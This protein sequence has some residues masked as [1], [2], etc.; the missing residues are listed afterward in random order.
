MAAKSKQRPSVA[1]PAA[2][3]SPMDKNKWRA[4]ELTALLVAVLVFAILV[5]VHFEQQLSKINWKLAGFI[6]GVS[7]LIF[8]VYHWQAQG[9]NSYD[10]IDMVMSKGKA[11]LDKHLTVFSFALAVWL[12]VQQALEKQPVTELMLGVLGF[13]VFKRGA[14]GFSDA[15]QNRPAAREPSQNVNVLQGASVSNS[16]EAADPDQIKK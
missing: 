4:L 3:A 9:N 2:P 12:I 16:A 6:V 13:F 14:Q 8:A 7:A 15:L 1:K 10:V 5:A 11:D